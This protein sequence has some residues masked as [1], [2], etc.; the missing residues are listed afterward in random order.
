MA[1]IRSPFIITG[2]L[3]EINFY[4]DEGVNVARRAGGGF[5]GKDIKT[6]PEMGRVRENSREFGHCSEVKSI[7]MGAL[8][9]Y[10]VGIR[11]RRIHYE[12]VSMFTQVKKQDAI[13]SR[14]ERTIEAGLAS[15]EGLRVLSSYSYPKAYS[16]YG[17]LG[18][19][20]RVDWT[21]QHCTFP[22]FNPAV[23]V[24]PEEATHLGLRFG[25]VCMDFVQLG[26]HL[27]PAEEYF[28]PRKASPGPLT[29]ALS[30]PVE[31]KGRRIGFLGVRFYQEVNGA[32]Y[33]LEAGR[34]AAVVG[35]R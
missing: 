16:L 27:F 8:R 29:L 25:I 9:P 24:F 13:S 3:G 17:V 12:M 18:C 7:F 26:A 32:Y 34:G 33:M 4:V 31:G 35:V 22:D 14:G 6:K 11:G 10:F 30:S 2:T 20:F 23:T 21:R 19:Q 5:N 15:T 1:R 28:V